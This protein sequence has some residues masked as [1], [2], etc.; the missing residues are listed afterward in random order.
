MGDIRF[1]A[2]LSQRTFYPPEVAVG[3]VVSTSQQGKIISMIETGY[4]AT[5]NYW[6]DWG[7]T[8]DNPETTQLQLYF[9]LFL[10]PVGSVSGLLSTENS[11]YVSGTIIYINTPKFPWRYE[12]Q[13]TE[14]LTVEGYSSSVSNPLNQS[15]INYDVNGINVP[16]PVRL[17]V[18]SS[19]MQNQLSDIIN[20]IVLYS[21]FK[22]EFG[23]EDGRFDN[24]DDANFFNTP[25]SLKK[26]TVENPMISDFKAI[27]SG[28]VENVEVTDKSMFVTVADTNR[29]LDDEVCRIF[30]IEEFPDAPSDTIDKKIPLLWGSQYNLDLF[31]VG[32]DKY[33][34]IDPEILASVDAVYDADGNLLEYIVSNG[35]ITVTSDDGEGGI[36]EASTADA[37]G[38]PDNKIGQIIVSEIQAKSGISYQEGPWDTTETDY[39]ISISSRINLYFDSGKVKDLIKKCLENDSAF[40]INKND[41]RLTLRQWGKLYDDHTIPSWLIMQRPERTNLDPKYYASSVA[42]EYN[43]N[44]GDD[45]Y[46]SVYL[47][48]LSE[49]NISGKF[50]KRQRKT[51]P[52]LLTTE[53]D[54]SSL[55]VRMLGRFGGR[56]EIWKV[57]VGYD[58]SEINPLDTVILTLSYNGR[59]VSN[60]Y[61]CFIVRGIN[62]AQDKLTLEAYSRVEN[63][64]MVL[65][66]SGIDMFL[67]S[68]GVDMIL[69][70][71]SIPE[72]FK[73]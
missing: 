53:S 15:D 63:Y 12:D 72:Q 60:F 2:E 66:L 24:S 25:V 34:V 51:Y 48:D 4:Q 16:Y 65:G 37:T 22:L 5:G 70:A 73:E 57:A 35:I 28:L 46:T 19:T 41:G 62:P 33:V 18:P 27:R 20:G 52:T 39:Y 68:T 36:V 38:S 30:T 69:G 47:N 3:A 31:D 49:K 21:S 11:F 13:G 8:Y 50:R 55:S 56:P 44:K 1:I 6:T 54:A 32:T 61:N 14:M 17:V 59:V 64:D 67:G 7:G 23:N 29:T 40:L 71:A 9:D 10:T 26:T 45:K 43:Y 58:C 42:V